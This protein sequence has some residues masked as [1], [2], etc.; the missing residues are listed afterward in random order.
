[1]KGLLLPAFE[2]GRIFV[3]QINLEA[4]RIGLDTDWI[5]GRHCGIRLHLK[6]S[7]GSS[8][9]VTHAEN[10]DIPVASPIKGI[11]ELL[12][13]GSRSIDVFGVRDYFQCLE[14]V[15]PYEVR[16]VIF[17][18]DTQ[19]VFFRPTVYLLP[20]CVLEILLILKPGNLRERI[21]RKV[22]AHFWGCERDYAFA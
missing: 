16:F 20:Y 17:F 3:G 15:L 18:I 11:L 19:N 10:I 12:L 7:R 4:D 6:Q 2:F 21:T 14:R 9:I 22:S 5:C 8:E 13:F 1:L